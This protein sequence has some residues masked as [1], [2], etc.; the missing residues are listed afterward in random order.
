M[1][2]SSPALVLAVMASMATLLVR[3][4]FLALLDVAP[5]PEV[6]A[7]GQLRQALHG[8]LFPMALVGGDARGQRRR[9]LEP[10]AGPGVVELDHASV[11]VLLDQRVVGGEE[12]IRAVVAD[13]LEADVL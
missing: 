12:D 7:A 10:A 13:R 2:V 9:R 5:L 3:D 4:P 1:T 11:Q 8:A 6:R